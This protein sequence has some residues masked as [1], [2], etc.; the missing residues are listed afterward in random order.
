MFLIIS[1]IL[2]FFFLMFCTFEA[3]KRVYAFMQWYNE[4]RFA[5]L[6]KERLD[7]REAVKDEQ[8]A[9]EL[10]KKIMRENAQEVASYGEMF[11][12]RNGI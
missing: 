7:R 12:Q 3:I 2:I 8:I 5:Q 6:R 11:L 9:T 1:K 10:S 4:F